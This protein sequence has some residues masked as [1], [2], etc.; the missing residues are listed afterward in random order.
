MLLF[1]FSVIEP[2]YSEI[3]FIITIMILYIITQFIY[4]YLFFDYFRNRYKR[5]N[6]K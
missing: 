5:R 1:N 3:A 6:E 4:D 2:N